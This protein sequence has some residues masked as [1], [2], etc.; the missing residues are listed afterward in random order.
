MARRQISTQRTHERP[1]ATGNEGAGETVARLVTIATAVTR[2]AEPIPGRA[3]ARGAPAAP[4]ANPAATSAVRPMSSRNVAPQSG[5]REP[6]S[7]SA[8]RVAQRYARATSA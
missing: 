8:T 6:R 5:S 4:S 3:D 7:G 1:T 2:R